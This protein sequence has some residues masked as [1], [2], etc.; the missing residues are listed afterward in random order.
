VRKTRIITVYVLF[1]L[2][3]FLALVG[4]FTQTRMFRERLRAVALAQL[5]SL[6]N[7]DIVLGELHG[8]LFSG[9]SLDSIRVDVGGEALLR[10]DR[11][12]LEY[13]LFSLPGNTISLRRITLDHPQIVLKRPAGGQWNVEALI[14][15]QANDTLTTGPFNRTIVL[16]NLTIIDGTLTLVDSTAL[17]REGHAPPDGRSVEY[18]AFTLRNFNLALSGAWRTDQK[19]ATIESCSFTAGTPEVRL[20][21]LSGVFTLTPSEARIE[22][23]RIVTARSALRLD[24]SM[25]DVDLMRGIELHALRSAPVDLVLR[26]APV[27]LDELKEFLPELGFL[28]GRVTTDLRANGEFGNLNVQQL[29]VRFGSSSL[30]VR[31][32]I[33]NLDDPENLSLSVKMTESTIVPA[34][35]P[36]LMPPFDLPDMSAVGTATLNLEFDGRPLDF[37]T[38]FLLETPAGKVQSSGLAL[39]IG[40]PSTL[41]YDGALLVGN[42]DLSRV[43][44]DRRMT[45]DLNGSA[46]V[47]GEGVRVHQLASALTLDIDSST[48]R[49]LP[50][51]NTHVVLKAARR[52]ITV[53]ANL[54]LGELRAELHGALDEPE[55]GPPAFHIDGNI[56]ALNLEHIMHDSTYNSDI[57]MKLNA[58]GSGLTWN[59]VNGEVVVDL[60]SSRYRDYNVTEGELH[61]SVDQKDSLQKTVRFVSNIADLTLTGAFDL[62]YLARL[63]PFEV[64]SLRAALDE[65]AA[66][67]DSSLAFAVDKKALEAARR[68]LAASKR[69]LDARFVL[70]VKDLEPISVAAGERTFNG[71]GMLT[72]A[73]LGGDDDLALSGDLTVNDFFYGN[74]N[75]GILVQDGR[76]RLDLHSLKPV[77]PLKDLAVHLESTAGKVLVN[78]NAMDSLGVTLDF[79]EE[80]ADYDLRALFN[81][82]WRL[83]LAGKA[84]VEENGVTASFQTL[85]G[86]YQNFTWHADPGAT[87]RVN[88]AS[89]G[90]TGLVMRCDTQTVALQASIGPGRTITLTVDGTHLDL[91]DMKYFLAD[92]E[93]G[94]QG[95]AFAGGAT[96]HATAAGTLASP[97]LSASVAGENISFR[98]LP[99][100]RLA[101]ELR[102]ANG[103]VDAH[104]RVNA[105]GD[106]PDAPPVMTIDGTLPADL[107]LEG[108]ENGLPDRVM[109]L[110]VVSRR[111]QMNVLDPLLPTFNQLRGVMTCD[112][113]L[114]GTPREP[115]YDGTIAIADCGFLFVPNN[116]YYTLAGTFHSSGERIAT[117][118]CT[119]RNVPE[120]QLSGR[121]GL[122][123]IG[124]DF[125]LRN[126]KPGDFNLRA[127]GKLLVVKETTRQSSLAVYGNLFAEIGPGPL[128]FTG[129]VQNS[130][131]KGSLLI[132][133]SSLIFPPTQASVAEESARSVPV[134][135]VDDT[136]TISAR[137][138]QSVYS[139]YLAAGNEER[140]QGDAELKKSKSFMDGLHYD[141]DI[142]TGGGNT[143]IRMIFNPATSEELVATIDGKFTITE[144]GKRWTG[145][146]T[147][148]RA[149]YNFFKRF[150]A[151]GSI[152]YTG[153]LMNP[154]LNIMATYRGVRTLVDST[155]ATHAEPVVVTV[156]IT[157]T[158]YEPKIEFSMT[159]DDIDYMSYHGPKS[160]DV[161][162]DAIQFIVAGT[163]PLTVTQKNELASQVEQTAGLS[164]L[165]GA[166]SLLTGR[167]SDYLRDQTG[168]I[169]SVELSYGGKESTELRL[170]GTAWSG[171]WRYGGTIL[172]DPLS[173]ANISIL[174]SFGTIFGNP[175]L[176]NLMFELERKV[177]PGTTGL[178]NDIKRI[179]SARVYYRFSF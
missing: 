84:R 83:R 155:S 94:P 80:K 133:N 105:E 4:A 143:E 48:F 127:E 42:L 53:Q 148:E 171:Y 108:T 79:R 59:T 135:F 60:S 74:A 86:A 129:E 130:L 91:D 154:E 173:N 141:L 159:I 1:G 61:L 39:R 7:A 144:D 164:L 169:N 166:T 112:L 138:D 2:P 92:E 160:N 140:S 41:A 81:K 16:G 145:D 116:I 87:V 110:K 71:S 18:H 30:F 104:V 70:H 126:L 177:E 9:F 103:E 17:G 44:D 175:A 10:L 43:L 57:T 172:N 167:L 24:A 66:V 95:T 118:D 73:I 68:S 124:G 36:A 139:R 178:S 82:N 65:K 85:E 157:G 3:L 34:D 97:V 33:A 21:R 27:D 45:S 102:Y 125:R 120:D 37:R 54:A 20:R 137:R 146:L 88:H 111:V 19:R 52:N 28:T 136:V 72:G 121:E 51:E 101:S 26:T 63:I 15:R 170:S 123:R 168:F 76:V 89:A 49:G 161:Q 46:A 107:R 114:G 31:G 12:D 8:N 150:D 6:L 99:F 47:N 158:R 11:L 179:N 128:R 69:H 55:N 147:V 14:R 153:D 119:L 50:V 132:R 38:K 5:D 75:A 100:G 40:G 62:G 77:R 122:M 23:L 25:K 96:V 131:L 115:T 22:S 58:D 98:T 134:V 156:K 64:R 106:P 109:N 113:T 176:R 13:N 78:R 32:G 149:Y 93:L 162:S 56:A 163:F 117:T 165:T 67:I 151:T 90:L 152:R 29:D 174:Y 35:V 142:E